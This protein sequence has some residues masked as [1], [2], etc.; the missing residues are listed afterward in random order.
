MIQ[1]PRT[2]PASCPG[3][4]RDHRT[5]CGAHGFL[6]GLLA[7]IALLLSIQ[8]CAQAQSAE[9]EGDR[10]TYAPGQLVLR[11]RGGPHSDDAKRLQLR[12]GYTV[13]ATAENLEL[14]LVALPVGMSVEEGLSRCRECPEVVSAEPNWAVPEQPVVPSTPTPSIKPPSGGGRAAPKHATDTDDPL[15]PQQ[16]ALDKIHAPEAWNITTGSNGVVVGILDTGINYTHEELQPNMWPSLGWECFGFGDLAD[17]DGHGTVIAGII[18]AVGNNGLGVAGLNWSSQLMILKV[19]AQTGV[20]SFDF[21][22]AFDFALGQRRQGANIVAVNWSFGLPSYYNDIA[23]AIGRITDAGVLVV[24]CAH[25]QTDNVDA[26][27]GSSTR[28]FPSTSAYPNLISV[29]ATDSR[30]RLA[31]FSNWGPISVDLAAPGVNIVSTGH[32]GTNDYVAGQYGTSFA[33]PHVAGT[34]ALLAAAY[35]AATAAQIKEAILE[36]VDLIEPLEGL[37]VKPGRLNVARALLHL[38]TNQAPVIVVSPE[39]RVVR[40]GDN[41]W[42][43]VGPGGTPPLSYQWYQGQKPIDEATNAMLL[44]TNVTENHLGLWARVTNAYGGADSPP[45]DVRINPNPPNVVGWGSRAHGECE[46]PLEATNLIA[47]AAGRWHTLGLR[48]DGTVVTWGDELAPIPDGLTGVKA[49]SAGLRFSMALLQDGSVR[50]WGNSSWGQTNLPPGLTDVAAI[51]AGT[52]NA[53][54]VRS[55]GTVI[56]WGWNGMGQTNVP[57]ELANVKSVAAGYAHSLALRNDGTVAAWGNNTDG[58]C[59]VPSDL[60]GVGAIAAGRGVSL[61]LLTNGTVRAW[62]GNTYGCLDIPS[63]LTNV[64]AIA[65]YGY[66]MALKQ[67]GTIVTWGSGM[68]NAYTGQNWGQALVPAGLSN[69]VAI[70]ATGS[71]SQALLAAPLPPPVLDIRVQGAQT[72]LSWGDRPGNWQ[73]RVTDSQSVPEWLPWLGLLSTNGGMVSTTVDPTNMAQFFR[74]QKV[75]D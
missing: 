24:V 59:N 41:A 52:A 18:G 25:N 42:L 19:P 17:H 22:N 44:L 21:V 40:A 35:P 65:A 7:S 37:L 34:V 63:G 39:N 49:I 64:V 53:L 26:P 15:R 73:L 45:A 3:R 1:F 32:T 16:W 50:V 30:D 71:H 56:A 27:A 31:A 57:P 67:D 20:Y 51:C 68:T 46:P 38:R 10:P 66:G 11:I 5:R 36:T 55:N 60:S 48:A 69:V 58:E 9:G 23:G 13:K 72:L 14:Q 70:S 33:A 6:N 75:P 29:A 62:G 47:V 54:V 4:T 43:T 28:S 2:I 74:L 61:A 12:L 8:A